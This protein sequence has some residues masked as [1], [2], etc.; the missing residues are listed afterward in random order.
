MC[1][2]CIGRGRPAITMRSHGDVRHTHILKSAH[3]PYGRILHP[4]EIKTVGFVQSAS[5]VGLGESEIFKVDKS[6]PHSATECC[7][8]SIAV[9]MRFFVVLNDLRWVFFIVHSAL[10]KASW[11]KRWDW[12]SDVRFFLLLSYLLLLPY[13]YIRV[14]VTYLHIYNPNRRCGVRQ[15]PHRRWNLY[16]Y[17]RPGR[18]GNERGMMCG[19]WNQSETC[20]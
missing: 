13:G 19:T 8:T 15:K 6:P 9:L 16:M 10:P 2:H 18:C 20:L 11:K 4:S 14:G 1:V 3:Q 5:R 12:V 17:N 7:E